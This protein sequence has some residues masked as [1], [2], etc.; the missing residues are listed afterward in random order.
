MKFSKSACAIAVSVLVVAAGAFAADHFDGPLASRDVRT[1]IADVYAFRSPENPDN[2][3]VA[4]DV[5]SHVPAGEP[6]PL[7]ST[8]TSYN[9]QVDNTGDLIP[10]ATVSVIF[11]GEG[12][13]SFEVLGLGKSL[14][15]TVTP[16]GATPL[17]ASRDGIRAFCGPRDD[18]FFFDLDGFK[19]FVAGPYVPVA[20]LRDAALGAPADFFAGR[21]I[22]AIVIELPIVALT[23]GA[24]S[25][26]GTIRT[27]AAITER[28]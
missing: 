17:V 23:G 4:V 19:K 27:W 18:P 10:D 24:D 13:Q 15:G 5:S 26:T 16:S 12:H 7:F 8:R 6:D 14:H 22:G 11:H 3:V 21:N 2:L 9:I 25:H 20:G 1:D 28:Q